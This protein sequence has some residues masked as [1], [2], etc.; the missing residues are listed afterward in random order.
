MEIYSHGMPTEHESRVNDN[1]IDRNDFLL[2]TG[3][4]KFRKIPRMFGMRGVKSWVHVGVTL[5]K[6]NNYGT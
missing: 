6:T 1:K 3:S 5:G 2:L 4:L